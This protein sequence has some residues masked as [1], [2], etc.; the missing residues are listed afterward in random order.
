M[1]DSYQYS[2][3][4]IIKGEH[5]KIKD[6]NDK[7]AFCV[8]ASMLGV[9]GTWAL[10]FLFAGIV[11]NKVADATLGQIVLLIVGFVYT[12]LMKEDDPVA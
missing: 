10:I 4:P 2:A 8:Y 3:P 6:R 12:R 11:E 5:M 9:I 1:R 7:I